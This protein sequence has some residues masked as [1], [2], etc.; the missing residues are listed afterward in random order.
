MI[1]GT[2]GCRSNYKSFEDLPK[3]KKN[4][5]NRRAFERGKK[6]ESTVDGMLIF[7]RFFIEIKIGT[8]VATDIQTHCNPNDL[9]MRQKKMRAIGKISKN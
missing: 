3:K 6:R 7:R 2:F 4:H 8:V 1:N 5:P 9:Q